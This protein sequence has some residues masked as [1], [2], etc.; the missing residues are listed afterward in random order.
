M[1]SPKETIEMAFARIDAALYL[2]KQNGRNR[3]EG[4]EAD[5]WTSKIGV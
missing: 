2:A 4:F 5:D 1:I 3:V